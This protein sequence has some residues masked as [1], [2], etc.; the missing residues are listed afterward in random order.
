[1]SM[2]RLTSKILASV[3]AVTVFLYAN[4]CN[5]EPSWDPR[6]VSDS[7]YCAAACEHIGSGDSGLN[8]EEGKPIEMKP[9]ACASVD[10]VDCVSC[11]KFCRDTQA[12]GV[13][14]NPRC[15]VDIVSCD[16][17]DSCQEVKR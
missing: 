11:E 4:S 7:E 6:P 3:V 15:V 1:M 14:L 10:D 2:Y 9:D 17:I 16:T 12:E 13:W 5:N 8:C